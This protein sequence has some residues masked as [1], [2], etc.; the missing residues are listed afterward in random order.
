M[1]GKSILLDLLLHC[2][3]VLLHKFPLKRP[4]MA[5]TAA[6]SFFWLTPFFFSSFRRKLSFKLM[7]LH[8]FRWTLPSWATR[9][10]ASPWKMEVPARAK[11]TGRISNA[12][13]P[14]CKADSRRD[15]DSTL[16]VKKVACCDRFI[17]PVT[18]HTTSWDRQTFLDVKSELR[19][20]TFCP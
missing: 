16:A 4:R 19:C 20:A 10:G 3:S 2:G 15:V 13:L 11:S 8:N 6:G 18:I 9:P 12:E 17:L 14:P 1:R 5:E 7:P